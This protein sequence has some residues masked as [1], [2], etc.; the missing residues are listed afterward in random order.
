[1]S[2]QHAS[3]KLIKNYRK[4]DKQEFV[5][6]NPEYSAKQSNSSSG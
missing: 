1:M 3:L 4:K 5:S 2:K 6:D